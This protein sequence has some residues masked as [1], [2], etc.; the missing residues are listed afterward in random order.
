MLTV[1]AQE[2]MPHL[3]AQ[4]CLHFVVTGQA[5]DQSLIASKVVDLQTPGLQMQVQHLSVSYSH[6]HC[7][8]LSGGASQY[9]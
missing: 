5:D 6:L 1:T 7:K 9:F 3:G 2:Y 4:L 8:Q